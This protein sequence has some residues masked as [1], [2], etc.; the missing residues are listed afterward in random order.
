MTLM[1]KMDQMVHEGKEAPIKMLETEE[2]ADKPAAV[3]FWDLPL[4]Q[5]IFFFSK[6]TFSEVCFFQSLF[7]MGFL[8]NKALSTLQ[9]CL[10]GSDFQRQLYGDLH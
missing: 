2:N 9:C 7:G 5:A 8:L 4:I 3:A 10:I 6:L 1:S